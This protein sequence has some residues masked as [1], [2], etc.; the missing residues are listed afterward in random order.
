MNA[1]PRACRFIDD[2][3]EMES[4]ANP[5]TPTPCTT[6]FTIPCP[7]SFPT[8][9]PRLISSPLSTPFLF[10][11]SLPFPIPR[12]LPISFPFS[13][14]R[15]F[16][17]PFPIPFSIPFP[18]PFPVPFPISFPIPF[19]LLFV[20]PFPFSV[21]FPVP[22]GR[23]RWEKPLLRWNLAGSGSTRPVGAFPRSS[24]PPPSNSPPTPLPPT[25]PHSGVASLA[26][27]WCTVWEG[28]ASALTSVGGFPSDP[29]AFPLV[30]Y[31][32]RVDGFRRRF[33]MAKTMHPRR[34]KA[35]KPKTRAIY[36]VQ[37]SSSS[38][39]RRHVRVPLVGRDMARNR[40]VRYSDRRGTNQVLV[41][42]GHKLDEHYQQRWYQERGAGGGGGRR[43]GRRDDGGA[44]QNAS[45][46]QKTA[47]SPGSF[48]AVS[49]AEHAAQ[50]V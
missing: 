1:S 37:G 8:S 15:P 47:P 19:P 43:E 16:A 49:S 26:D 38:Q 27:I 13:F 23:D 40:G 39:C 24:T 29:K 10:L 22:F 28:T 48:S 3:L 17:L 9:V 30:S 36:A 31:P 7:I 14:P 11:S 12:P 35:A 21:S 34:D 18:I 5:P 41:R 44:R 46:K 2:F 45:E 50:Q 20:I 33:S 32:S 6:P 42:H 4:R 25:L